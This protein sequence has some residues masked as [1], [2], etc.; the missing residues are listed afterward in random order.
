MAGGARVVV[1]DER[2]TSARGPPEQVFAIALE[3]E[4]TLVSVDDWLEDEHSAKTGLI[5]LIQMPHLSSIGIPA[6]AG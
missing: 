4:A 6:T 1:L 5:T 3:E 2:P